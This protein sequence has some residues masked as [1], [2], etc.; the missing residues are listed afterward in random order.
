MM[1]SAVA[2]KVFGTKNDRDIKKLQPTVDRINALEAKVS[3][4]TDE[5][6]RGKTEEFKSIL[7]AIPTP[8]SADREPLNCR[9]SAE[10]PSHSDR[11]F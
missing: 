4:L 5:Q 3:Q 8:C 9:V 7:R 10:T 6:L 1:L 11:N 2:K